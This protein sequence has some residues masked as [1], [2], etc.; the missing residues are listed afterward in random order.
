MWSL[1]WQETMVIF[2]LALLL[3]GPKKL[4]ELGK[5]IAKGLAEFRRASSDLKAT[6][7][8]EMANIERE[9]NPIKET[10]QELQSSTYDYSYYENSY[11]ENSYFDSDGTTSNSPSQE[12]TESASA[13]QGAESATLAAPAE[14]GTP[15]GV[16]PETG[17]QPVPSTAPVELAANDPNSVEPLSVD[18][19]VA[20][21]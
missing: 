11:Y 13:T 9:T 10:V 16:T 20:R 3:F 15:N 6:F 14:A 1:G 5:N 18:K 12:S 7:D 4:P 19:P 2:L 21:S 17:S 8:R